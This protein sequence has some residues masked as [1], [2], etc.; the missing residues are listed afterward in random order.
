MEEAH[1]RYSKNQRGESS[2]SSYLF[3]AI[4]GKM[5]CMRIKSQK[6]VVWV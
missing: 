3:G 2:V 4:A 5:G 1:I 6:F